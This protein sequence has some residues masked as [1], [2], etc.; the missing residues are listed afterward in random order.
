M[1]G[2]NSSIQA[3]STLAAGLVLAADGLAVR[4][5]ES[6]IR[7]VHQRADAT[8]AARTVQARPRLGRRRC[9]L[10]GSTPAILRRP[11]R[12]GRCV[13][14]AAARSRAARRRSESPFGRGD[15]DGFERAGR[16][17]PA[18]RHLRR[19]HR[20]RLPRHLGP[21]T[22]CFCAVRSK[23]SR[24]RVSGSRRTVAHRP[25]C[26]PSDHAGVAA[27]IELKQSH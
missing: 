8:H 17:D 16:P 18:G 26:G 23:R 22:A 12:S 6:P 4:L 15:R 1:N 19:F 5:V 11:P 9:Q 14:A 7:P 20:V 10:P 21:G 24:P 25:A 13:A 27:R 2:F 3:I